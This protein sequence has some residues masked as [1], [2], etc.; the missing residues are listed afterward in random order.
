ME[1][2]MTTTLK[3]ATF[4]VP[5]VMIGF[6]GE[7]HAA[8][9]SVMDASSVTRFIS[10][11]GSTVVNL[12]PISSLSPSSFN[13]ASFDSSYGG[14]FSGYTVNTKDS[15]GDHIDISTY[16]AGIKGSYKG[17]PI[18]GG[19]IDATY[20]NDTALTGI[21]NFVQFV[22]TNQPANG[23]ISPYVDPAKNDDNLPFYWTEAER[24]R[25]QSGKNLGFQDFSTRYTDELFGLTPK[26][27]SITWE[28]DLYHVQWDGAKAITVGGGINWGWE[29]KSATK[30][31]A[32]ASFVNPAPDS[33][34]VSGVG[35]NNFSWGSGQ[36]SQLLFTPKSF[37][38]KPDE[39]FSLGILSFF[40]GTIAS[41][42][43]ADSVDLAIDLMFNNAIE[44][45]QQLSASLAIV[46]T[47]N[48]DDPIASAD[49]VSFTSG[50]FKSSFNVLEGA[51]A[52]VD[53]FARFKSAAGIPIVLPSDKSIDSPLIFPSI[54]KLDIEILGFG[55]ASEFGFIEGDD[56]SGGNIL[57]TTAI[58][59]PSILPGLISMGFGV[60]RKRRKEP[61]LEI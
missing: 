31:K 23:A 26:R 61:R 39:V 47:L 44:N 43:G 7:S 55:N 24:P 32:N 13:K 37:N 35:S 54:S 15:K 3:L 17:L 51:N 21:P 58:P 19:K 12:K 30:G 27:D 16:D 28:A 34:V 49:S 4:V 1:I 5:L 33:A 46:N 9:F 18:I 42:S 20:Q 40:N 6:V 57:G 48:T 36:P 52:S 25:Y 22:N 14:Q 11:D 29:A 60:L 10:P 56:F 50:G 53:L 38:P 41:A 2:N 45:N 8:T 59:T